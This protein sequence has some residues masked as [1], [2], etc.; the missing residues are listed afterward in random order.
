MVRIEPSLVGGSV[1]GNI[2][3][4]NISAITTQDAINEL[5]TEKVAKAGDTMLGS[6]G[7]PI[8]NKTGTYTATA[9]DHTIICDATSGAFTINLPTAVGITG[10]VY[11]IKKIDATGNAI[12]VDGATTET[13]DGALTKL[14]NTQYLSV[15]I[16]SNGTNWYI[17]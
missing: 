8:V 12:T 2:P 3:A 14:V 7:L 1:I 4:G 9:S 6:L 10:R 17:I 11:V 5:D 16:Q 13:I 15:T